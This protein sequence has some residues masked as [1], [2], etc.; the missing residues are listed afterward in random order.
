MRAFSVKATAEGETP[1]HT[2]GTDLACEGDTQSIQLAQVF[3]YVRRAQGNRLPP[4][5]RTK[6]E[7]KWTPASKDAPAWFREPQPRRYAN[8]VVPVV[9]AEAYNAFISLPPECPQR[10]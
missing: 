2:V 3:D 4:Q 1:V 7:H 6:G 9:A 10:N 5:A 8:T